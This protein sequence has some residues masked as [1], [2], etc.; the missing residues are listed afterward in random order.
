MKTV[1]T[2]LGLTLAS[3]AVAQTTHQ[4]S[5]SST[6]NSNMG[7]PTAEQAFKNRDA[8]K[9]NLLSKAEVSGTRLAAA[10]D[11]L[12]TNKDGML[13]LEEVQKGGDGMRGRDRGPRGQGPGAMHNERLEARF[14]E[15]DANKDGFLSKA[16][17]SARIDARFAALDS[18]KDGKL[19]LDEIKAGRP[20]ANKAN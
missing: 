3:V 10:F 19:S 7:R 9:D 18:N 14:K 15:G 2:L 16:E 13:G 17:F 20:A 1:Y 12:D 5:T 8:N 11:R 6:A 4:N